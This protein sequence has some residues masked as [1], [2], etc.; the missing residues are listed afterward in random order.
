M[1]MPEYGAKR[2][3][4][5]AGGTTRRPM[6]QTCEK[7]I[8]IPCNAIQ[9]RE[10]VLLPMRGC[11]V[12]TYITSTW[13]NI[14]KVKWKLNRTDQPLANSFTTRRLGLPAQ[15]KTYT[16]EHTTMIIKNTM[17]FLLALLIEVFFVTLAVAAF[18]WSF[19]LVLYIWTPLDE[20]VAL[21]GLRW[22]DTREEIL[23]LW[24]RVRNVCLVVYLMVFLETF[25]LRVSC[26]LPLVV[27][28]T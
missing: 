28:H 23:R 18:F 2:M 25:L 17:L 19:F 11:E 26:C 4:K 7:T 13:A 6:I 14:P 22:V 1:Y 21:H 20:L 27:E 15:R 24:R 9:L 16:F 5:K 3:K 8:T 10:K 12:S